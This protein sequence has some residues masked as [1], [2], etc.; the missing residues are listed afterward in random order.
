VEPL[1]FYNKM[2]K[3]IDRNNERLHRPTS[4]L[5]EKPNHLLV[6]DSN[7]RPNSA[8]PSPTPNKEFFNNTL[9]KRPF[10]ASPAL[11][12]SNNLSPT[13]SSKRLS[14]SRKRSP[15]PK[16][17]SKG[18]SPPIYNIGKSR[19]P[20]PPRKQSPS[21]NESQ[22]LTDLE[23]NINDISNNETVNKEII[24]KEGMK[25]KD[26]T[27]NKSEQSIQKSTI[28]PASSSSILSLSPVMV[29]STEIRPKSSIE[30]RSETRFESRPKSAFN[31]DSI[32]N[33]SKVHLDE[34]S[35]IYIY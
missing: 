31:T 27:M 3:A 11:M 19:P 28:R 4:A 25:M 23:I 18:R 14:P 12:N 22:K 20:L 10:S 9:S 34:S 30:V 29:K 21:I 7:N 5:V 6:K 13:P 16:R 32:S 17:I 35:G 8:C 33:I 24:Q 2:T 26:I 15:S 1:E